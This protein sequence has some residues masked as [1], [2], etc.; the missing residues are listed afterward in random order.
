MLFDND[1]LRRTAILEYL[2]CDLMAIHSPDI[3]KVK[4]DEIVQLIAHINP[5]YL[6][7]S[8]IRENSN[9]FKYQE[10]LDI[11][12]LRYCD[13]AKGICLFRNNLYNYGIEHG[14]DI[15]I[16]C[17]ISAEANE[18][19]ERDVILKMVNRGDIPLS[20]V[21]NAPVRLSYHIYGDNLS[22]IEFN[23]P[24]YSLPYDLHP[25]HEIEFKMKIAIPET[26]GNAYIK[27]DLIQEGVRWFHA[28]CNMCKI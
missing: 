28:K 16:N 6:M 20:N 13:S 9:L 15:E 10:L 3:A 26:E 8:N 7:F 22:Y 27:F 5:K 1:E 2:A 12:L 11:T 23:N 25:H 19:G 4:R 18:L 21:G 24:R 17:E 14:C